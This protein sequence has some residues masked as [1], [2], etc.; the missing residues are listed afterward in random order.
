MR[1]QSRAPL[2]SRSLNLPAELTTMQQRAN[3]TCSLSL[4]N[5]S[6]GCNSGGGI[7]TMNMELETT[8]TVLVAVPQPDKIASGTVAFPKRPHSL[9]RGTTV[10]SEPIWNGRRLAG[11]E[12]T[13]EQGQEEETISSCQDSGAPPRKRTRTTA[14]STTRRTRRLT[15]PIAA[16]QRVYTP[17]ILT[18]LVPS[19]AVES[20]ASSSVIVASAP[21]PCSETS[22]LPP[23]TPRLF[24]YRRRYNSTDMK[25][26]LYLYR[27]LVYGLEVRYAGSGGA[28]GPPSDSQGML[29]GASG[30]I[31]SLLK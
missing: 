12:D 30:N 1:Y 13:S 14:L 6:V 16:I 29:S 23:V 4:A 28:V 3:P 25:V 15:S 5:V 31:V 11:N 22:A 8:P 7:S 17:P 20:E 10:S 26:I 27:T 24:W 18:A 2:R 21:F 19:S 9:L